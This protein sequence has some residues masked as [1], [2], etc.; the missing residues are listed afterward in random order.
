MSTVSLED[1][2]AAYDAARARL[3]GDRII[4]LIVVG[5]EGGVA[6]VNSATNATKDS[7]CIKVLQCELDRFGQAHE[8][9]YGYPNPVVS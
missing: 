5:E 1:V 8:P 4:Y 7:I 3:P 2:R 9:L 6:V